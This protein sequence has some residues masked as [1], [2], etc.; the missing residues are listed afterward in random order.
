MISESLQRTFA[1]ASSGRKLTSQFVTGI[2]GGFD[3][4]DIGDEVARETSFSARAEVMKL[5]AV[6]AVDSVY[7]NTKLV[8]EAFK[9]EIEK[10]GH[11]VELIN[12][13]KEFR[14][15]S[16]GDLLFIGSPTRVA[17]MTAK[18]KKFVK[19]LDAAAWSGKTVVVFDTHMP[20]PDDPEKQKKAMKWVEPGAAGRLSVLTAERG[21]KVHSPPLRFMVSDMKGP[22]APGELEKARAL[23]RE[24]I[25]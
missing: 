10:A 3:G 9:E 22:L 13:R 11:E 4:N 16:E 17:K 21:L 5:K 14:V 1:L 15:P 20:L 24:I 12:L 25:A 8:A 7:G 2:C 23:A 18:A 6:I 19:K